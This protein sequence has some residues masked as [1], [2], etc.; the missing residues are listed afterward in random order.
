VTSREERAGEVIEGELTCAACGRRH[1]VHGSIPRFVPPANYASSFGFQWNRFRAT[2]L[3]SRSG[4]EISKERFFR[5]TGWRPEDL[6]GS[7]VLDVG[8]GAGR[9][10]EVALE[11]GANVVALDYSSA[12]EACRANLASGHLHVI[13]GDIFELP[14]LSERFDFVYCFGVLQHT[15]DPAGAFRVIGERLK[16]GTRLAVDIYPNLVRNLFWPK[17]WL[18]PITKRLSAERLFAIVNWMVPRLLPVSSAIGRIPLIGRQ[19]RYLVPVMNY[20][21]VLPLSAEQLCEWAALDTFDMFAAA[22]DHPRS[23]QDVE[24]WFRSL[25]WIDYEVF[26]TGVV[27]GRGTKPAMV[28]TIR[29]A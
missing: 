12:V 22:H 17:Y 5:Q 11:A 14:V 2:Q 26:R 18:R 4:V 13:Q 28:S 16:A 21:G 20:S 19:L 24:E 25:G 29:E 15:P 10:A 1:P 7:W 23:V 6:A 27:V 3:D 9:F 8:C